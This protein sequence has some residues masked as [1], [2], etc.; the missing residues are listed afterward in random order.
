MDNMAVSLMNIDFSDTLDNIKTAV[1]NADKRVLVVLG[2]AAGSF[3]VYQT[4]DA[5]STAGKTE[6]GWLRKMHELVR[7]YWNRGPMIKYRHFFYD[8]KLSVVNYGSYG[9][10]PKPVLQ[11]KRKL[12]VRSWQKKSVQIVS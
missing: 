4:L 7:V 3:A 12:Q 1:Y 5:I 2:L 11:H 6:V 10:V 9:V 8:P